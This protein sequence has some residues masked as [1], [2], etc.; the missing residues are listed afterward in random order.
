MQVDFHA[1]PGS[2]NGWNH[3]GKAGGMVGWMKG[4]MGIANAQRHLENIRSV[5]EYIS[6]E[7]IKQVVPMLGLV[8]EV[9]TK[10]VPQD[11]LGSL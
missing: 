10:N 3:S 8:N 4:I 5:T 11:A 9:Q 6:Q 7:G 1:L 2:Q